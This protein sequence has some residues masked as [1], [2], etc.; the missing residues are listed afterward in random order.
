MRSGP[1][2]S[3]LLARFPTPFHKNTPFTSFNFGHHDKVYIPV[4]KEHELVA[5]TTMND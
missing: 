5:R 2:F 3:N 4:P 1:A